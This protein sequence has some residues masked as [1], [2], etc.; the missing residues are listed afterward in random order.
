MDEALRDRFDALLE[1]ALERLPEQVRAWLD[2][3]P[4]IV[5]DIPDEKTLASLAQEHGEPMEPTE[6]CGLH[7]G[8]A[9]TERSID[10]TA[11]VELPSEIF[12]FREGIVQEAGGWESGDEDAEEADDAIYEQIVVTLLHELGHQFGLNEDDLKRLGYD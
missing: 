9:N 7:T 10:A 2:R 12:L 4:V 6:L 5:E 1:E 3:I 8:V 11:G